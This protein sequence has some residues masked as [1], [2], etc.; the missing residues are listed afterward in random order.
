M[1]VQFSP[2]ASYQSGCM[3]CNVQWVAS[4]ETGT[5]YMAYIWSGWIPLICDIKVIT[6]GTALPGYREQL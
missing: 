6:V 3:P 1:R 4:L 5:V 2:D